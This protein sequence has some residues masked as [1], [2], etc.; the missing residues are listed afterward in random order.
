MVDRQIAFGDE[1]LFAIGRNCLDLRY[2]LIYDL[3]QTLVA[4][5]WTV[6]DIVDTNI[7]QLFS[8]I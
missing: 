4:M 8:R 2:G 6:Q 3:Q 7:L 5:F 1:V